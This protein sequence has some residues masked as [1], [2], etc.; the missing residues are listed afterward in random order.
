MR[1]LQHNSIVIYIT[2]G[3]YIL[4]YGQ[5]TQLR[6]KSQI[7]II[8]KVPNSPGE[9]HKAIIKCSSF[10]G[11]SF[12]RSE[13]I[14]LKSIMLHGCGGI[15]VSTSRNLSSQSFELL[16]FQV[17]VYMLYCQ[18]VHIVHVVIESSNG[19]GLT[20]Y[21][22]VGNVTLSGCVFKENGVGVSYGEGGLQIEWSYC[23]LENKHSC[24]PSTVD[25]NNGSLFNIINS[26][27]TF[28]MAQRGL[29]II[30]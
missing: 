30:I 11:L 10:T 12:L 1:G 21:N 22:T 3:N 17:A 26:S 2:P 5:E 19:T 7:A 28:N 4:E 16:I 18:N 24:T 8:G 27:F 23:N 6:Y 25:T 14:I 20:M 15:Q 13:D 9:Q 29:H